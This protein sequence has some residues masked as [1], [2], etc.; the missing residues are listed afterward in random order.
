MAGPKRGESYEAWQ[1]RRAAE[2]ESFLDGLRE[3]EGLVE[4]GAGRFSYRS[5]AFFHF[6][7]G[8]R[9]RVAD[10]RLGADWVR[11]PAETRAELERIRREI[12]RY[13]SADAA[14]R[15]APRRPSA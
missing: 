5:K 3:I 9:D 12:V 10:V 14:R 13:V 4:R 15:R 2:R 7:G 1:S 6:H 8:D 11:L